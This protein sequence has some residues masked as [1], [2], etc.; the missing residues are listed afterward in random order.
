MRDMDPRS[1][2]T[3]MEIH[4]TTY[5]PTGEKPDEFNLYLQGRMS[6]LG[7]D[8]KTIAANTGIALPTVLTHLNLPGKPIKPQSIQ[9]FAAGRKCR[10]KAH[11]RRF[12][13]FE[14]NLSG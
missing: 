11:P 13:P 10:L 6:E 4:M 9:K 3:L 7:L 14:I 8:P 5:K 1:T 12:S 2:P